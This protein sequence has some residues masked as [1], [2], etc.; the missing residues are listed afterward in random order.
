MSSTA[1]VL[2]H[3]P[4]WLPA[5]SII[6]TTT[7][8][9]AALDQFGQHWKAAR[10]MPWRFCYM[11]YEMLQREMTTA[12]ESGRL[13][14][15]WIKIY[16]FYMLKKG[17]IDRRILSFQDQK[18]SASLSSTFQ[19]LTLEILQL[20]RFAELNYRGFLHLFM[21][22]DVANDSDLRKV[23]FQKPF[24]TDAIEYHKLAI[25]ANYLYLTSSL[26]SPYHHRIIST[27]FKTQQQDGTKAETDTS[28]GSHV[29]LPQQ[30][31]DTNNHAS[32][33]ANNY[34]PLVAYS[35]LPCSIHSCETT[36]PSSSD[37]CLQSPQQQQQHNTYWLHPS[38]MLEVMLYL[39]DKTL[40]AQG[41]SSACQ[42][43][44]LSE[45]GYSDRHHTWDSQYKMTTL[46]MDT[47]QLGGYTQRLGGKAST[48]CLTRVRWYDS[49][50]SLDDGDTTHSPHVMVE[51]QVHDAAS[52]SEER[53]QQ[54]VWL[55]SKH[56]QPWLSGSFS[57]GSILAKDACQYHADGL[58]VAVGSDDVIHEMKQA[59]LSMERPVHTG[60][61]QPVLKVT[62]NRIVYTSMDQSITI[63][64]DSDISMMCSQQTAVDPFPFCVVGITTSSS[65]ST[66]TDHAENEWF[67]KLMKCG[68][69]TPVDGFSAFLHGVGTLYKDVP[70]P[71]WTS[72]CMNDTKHE[73]PLLIHPQ[74][75]QQQHGKQNIITAKSSLD[76]MQTTATA[77]GSNSSSSNRSSSTNTIATIVTC[78]DDDLLDGGKQ[79]PSE[80]ESPVLS[81][82]NSP[83]LHPQDGG[84]HFR[85]QQDSRGGGGIRR[86]FDSYCSFDHP[87]SSR[88][89]PTNCKN[90][91]DRMLF[92]SSNSTQQQPFAMDRSRS[93]GSLSSHLPAIVSSANTYEK[94]T[95]T[96]SSFLL[97]TFWPRKF[98]S[99]EKEPLLVQHH[100]HHHHRK[101][102]SFSSSKSSTSMISC[103]SNHCNINKS[104]S[105]SPS[106][107]LPTS[108][109][110]T[111]ERFSRAAIL[112]MTCV[113]MSLSMSCILY[114]TILS[115]L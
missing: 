48:T 19:S 3:L 94:D 62:H 78:Y 31:A 43:P 14:D 80:Q 73:Q 71:H 90:C 105:A 41:S 72:I 110:S 40:I 100:H 25:E 24:W 47:P 111:A 10:Y 109:T 54:R 37:M 70:T 93:Y 58:T 23:I 27:F 82:A 22:Y 79:P 108:T 112:T 53:V 52:N 38:N 36:T 115:K 69:L 42:T 50:S 33:R 96:F 92:S 113:V 84:Y 99:F 75:P 20:Y 104:T 68:M 95:I 87:T 4:Q 49:I 13:Q 12:Q 28:K 32:R 26:V 83:R 74:T 59:C 102:R 29:A 57:L 17:E 34:G 55:K 2:H 5:A 30:Q 45:I 89:D 16:D 88:S 7:T 51:Q 106:T 67:V 9:M 1:S 107:Q 21:Q 66:S 39:S 35:P 15:E 81:A 61:I 8:D 98:R 77:S 11:D 56:L 86:S 44:A 76:S 46:Y 6:S 97:Q 60:Q 18:R 64:I 101:H 85:Q 91:M 63:S 65:S 114:I 103:Q